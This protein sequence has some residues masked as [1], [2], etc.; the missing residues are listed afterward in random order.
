MIR[1][2]MLAPF[3]LALSTWQLRDQNGNQNDNDLPRNAQITIPWFA[4]GFMFMAVINSL[5]ILP[6]SLVQSVIYADDVMMTTAM[7]ALGL[8]SHV[9]A[10]RKAGIKPLLLAALM[11]GWLVI[12]G[13][14]INVGVNLLLR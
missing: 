1:V 10:F 4:V 11:F 13:G 12:G 9:S 7:A 5:H 3:L 6:A 8:T 14:M 2:L